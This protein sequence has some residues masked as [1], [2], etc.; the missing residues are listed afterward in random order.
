[1]EKFD[2]SWNSFDLLWKNN[3]KISQTK[4][5]EKFRKSLLLYCGEAQSLEGLMENMKKVI[6]SLLEDAAIP[7]DISEFDVIRRYHVSGIPYRISKMIKYEFASVTYTDWTPQLH[8]R[9][10]SDFRRKVKA[11]LLGSKH[12]DCPVEITK[13]IIYHLDRFHTHNL[14]HRPIDCINVDQDRKNCRVPYYEISVKRSLLKC[15]T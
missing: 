7:V 9:T 14:A 1:M 5:G 8:K 4:L 15:Y 13:V 10:S 6:I 12:R 11:F 3:G 2:E